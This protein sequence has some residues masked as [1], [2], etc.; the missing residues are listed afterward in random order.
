MFCPTDAIKICGSYRG[1]DLVDTCLPEGV[2][3]TKPKEFSV[4]PGFPHPGE[5]H[6]HG[7]WSAGLVI[8]AGDDSLFIIEKPDSMPTLRNP[9][10][11]D[12]L[13]EPRPEEVIFPGD[14]VFHRNPAGL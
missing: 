6:H 7:D 10:R 3:E 9:D 11:V 13:H 5:M 8:A 1:D 4:E 2:V 12:P 14:N